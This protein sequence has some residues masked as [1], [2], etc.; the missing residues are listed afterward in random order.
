MRISYARRLPHLSSLVI[1]ECKFYI[2]YY[3][4]INFTLKYNFDSFESYIIFF[5]KERYSYFESLYILIHFRNSTNACNS[6]KDNKDAKN[7]YTQILILY[8]NCILLSHLYNYYCLH[9]KKKGWRFQRMDKC[10]LNYEH[11]L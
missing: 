3:F 4:F 5:L 2:C 8:F 11:G 6:K 1:P 7:S 10:L 9:L